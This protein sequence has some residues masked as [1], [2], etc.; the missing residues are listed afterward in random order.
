[1]RA[2][3][4]IHPIDARAYFIT[5]VNGTVRLIG[6]FDPNFWCKVSVQSVGNMVIQ[7]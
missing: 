2:K 1:M 7:V 6:I 5:S 4:W 3:L